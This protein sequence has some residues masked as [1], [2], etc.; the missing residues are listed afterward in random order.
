MP[1][2]VKIRI[3]LKNFSLTSDQVSG[4]KECIHDVTSLMVLLKNQGAYIYGDLPP[5][6]L[7]STTAMGKR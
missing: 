3:F 1:F 5:P 6:L 2:F 4:E 7:S